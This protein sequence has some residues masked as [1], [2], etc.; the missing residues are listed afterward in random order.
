M[1][2]PDFNHQ[3]DALPSQPPPPPAHRFMALLMV[4]SSGLVDSP[5]YSCYFGTTS[6]LGPITHHSYEAVACVAFWGGYLYSVLP[7]LETRGSLEETRTEGC[8]S[9]C[10]A[11]S[12]TQSAVG[13]AAVTQLI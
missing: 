13:A 12:P 9:Y 3:A 5:S 2:T 6:A 7:M 8:M 1:A 11:R 10:L 4:T